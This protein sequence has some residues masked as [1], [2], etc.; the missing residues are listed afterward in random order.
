M[1]FKIEEISSTEKKALFDID[2]DEVAKTY[3][4]VVKLFQK[5]ADLKGFRKGKVPLKVVESIYT[6]QIDEEIKTRII[7]DNLRVLAAEEKI[8]IV[9]TSN[10]QFKDF[11]KDK[12]FQFSFNFELIPDINLGNYKS[13]EVEKEV[14]SIEQKDIDKAIENLLVNFASNEEVVKRKKIQKK[15]I[16]SINFSGEV[17]GVIVKDLVRENAMIELG[18]D[19]LIPDIEIKI[20]SMTLNEEKIFDV[21]YPK[22]FPI[23]EAAGKVVSCK[24]LINKIYKK[25]IPKL[26]DDFMAKLGIESKEK[27]EERVASDLERSSNEKSEASLRRNIGD[28]L[29][30]DNQFEFPLSFL[31]DE[32][33][34]L[35][36]EYLGRMNEKG[37]KMNEV[38]EKTKELIK[39][40]ALRNVKLAL[41]FAEISKVENIVVGEEEVEQVISSI[42][43]SQ[44]TQVSK[45]K[46]YYKDNNLMD[47]VKVKLTDEKVIRFLVSEAKIKEVKPNV[48]K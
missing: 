47:D 5:D 33:K 3:L 28:K 48:V 8:N 42:A 43:K 2:K 23:A 40:S 10:L 30:N 13:L 39:E 38:D 29:I 24:V 4:S 21:T 32:E 45:V 18:N 25:V 37:I 19:S 20:K 15:D 12:K 41:I 7:N 16:L 34:R 27:L 35:E 36:S 46:N 31:S 17:G 1:S 26:D 6:E 22:D 11:D 44:N 9:K 14:F